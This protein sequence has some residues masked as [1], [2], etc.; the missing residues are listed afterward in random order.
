VLAVVPWSSVGQSINRSFILKYVQKALPSPPAVESRLQ[1]VLS[2]INVPSLFASV[3][4]PT[5]PTGVRGTLVT[6]HHVGSPAAVVAVKAYGGCGTY[7]EGTG[8][9]VAPGEVVTAAHVVAGET[10]VTVQGRPG[11]VVLFD[12][13]SDLAVVRVPG[14]AP[15]PLALGAT[16]SSRHLAQVVG[17]VTP[18]D[19]AA[20]S[21]LFLGSV[22]APGRDIYSGAVFSRTADVVV[23]PLDANESGSPVLVHG[24]VVAVVAQRAVSDTTL[25]YA[26]PVAQ[27][28]SALGHVSAKRVS[29]QR[30][31]N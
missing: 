19:R 22:T 7:P 15:T 30:C 21:A 11:E 6:T 27:L 4:A 16:T 28:R 23:A 29:T 10:G 14:L 17:Y 12:P 26:I 8:F 18:S 1:G 5:L 2:E 20:T 31:V 13:R 3:V 24:A 25:S 9:V